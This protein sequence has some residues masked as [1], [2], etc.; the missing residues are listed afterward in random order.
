MTHAL[1]ESLILGFGLAV[2]GYLGNEP[3]GEDVSILYRS[4]S[5]SLL[6]CFSN[7][8]ININTEYGVVSN[9]KKMIQ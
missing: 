8:C 7:E 1:C 9:S 3:M 6:L 2:T 4:L 5:V